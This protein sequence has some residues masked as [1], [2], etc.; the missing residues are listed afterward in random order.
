MSG[1]DKKAKEKPNPFGAFWPDVKTEKGRMDAIKG[2]A[3]VMVYLIISYTLATAVIVFS[4]KDIH[5]SFTD[6]DE[7]IG[8]M[9]LNVVAII[10][11]SLLAWLVWKRQSPIAAGIGMLWISVEVVMKLATAPGRGV[12]L[13]LVVLLFGIHGVRGTLAAKRASEQAAKEA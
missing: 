3:T 7:L 9:I 12:V 11:A 10:M 2:G 6:Q 1:T 5:G 8:T 13:A 4:G